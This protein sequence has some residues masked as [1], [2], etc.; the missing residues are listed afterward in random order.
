[1]VPGT[2]IGQRRNQQGFSLQL[3]GIFG[4]LRE[5]FVMAP[6]IPGPTRLRR[7]LH[8]RSTSRPHRGKSRQ[9]PSHLEQTQNR[10]LQRQAALRH[11]LTLC[12]VGWNY[13]FVALSTSAEPDMFWAVPTNPRPTPAYTKGKIP[14]LETVPTTTSAAPAKDTN[15][16]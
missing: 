5:G 14:P 7:D 16:P 1:M 10:L 13:S 6:G 3:G 2:P 12:T 8:G 11:R 4:A 9:H 15:V